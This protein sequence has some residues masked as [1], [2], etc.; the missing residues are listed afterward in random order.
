MAPRAAIIPARSTDGSARVR[1]TNQAISPSDSAQRVNGRA[2]ASS[3]PAAARRNA[4][5]WPHNV[6]V[7]GATDRSHHHLGHSP[8]SDPTFRMLQPA[9]ARQSP[10][11]NRLASLPNRPGWSVVPPP[12]IAT[13]AISSR[14]PSGNY[15]WQRAPHMPRTTSRV[16][17]RRS[18]VRRPLS[19]HAR[20]GV[21]RSDVRAPSTER[22]L[23]SRCAGPPLGWSLPYSQA[24]PRDPCTSKGSAIAGG[25]T[26]DDFD[27]V[28]E[29]PRA[30][31][32]VESE[33]VAY[34]R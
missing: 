2:R 3:G 15:C 31:Y 6:T 7:S 24:V 12:H 8:T 9:A 4:T 22:A 28:P 26:H 29:E 32:S 19:A 11:K 16:K 20:R 30:S 25:G 5:F 33:G 21:E 14:R 18:R 27:P 23:P 17:D 34:E 13:G 10:P 1:T